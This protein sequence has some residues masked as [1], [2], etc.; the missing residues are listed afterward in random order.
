MSFIIFTNLLKGYSISIIY[1]K[2]AIIEHSIR[3]TPKIIQILKVI[4]NPFGAWFVQARNS[5]I[6]PKNTQLMML[7]FAMI[8]TLGPFNRFFSMG[9]IPK[10]RLMIMH[11]IPNTKRILE[12]PKY[13]AFVYLDVL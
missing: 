1:K 11:A 13:R 2:D 4:N 3:P 8:R 9:K 7:L 5:R 12:K 10:K 6:R